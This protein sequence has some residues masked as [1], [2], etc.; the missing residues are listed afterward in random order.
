MS[1][2][3][4]A[5]KRSSRNR[6]FEMRSTRDR[7]QGLDDVEQA[8]GASHRVVPPD[9]VTV[10]IA[11]FNLMRQTSALIATE[12]VSLVIYRGEPDEITSIEIVDIGAAPGDGR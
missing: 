12:T 7:A 8:I 6:A 2:P 11:L 5:I 10:S 3:L 1:L 4:S 9:S